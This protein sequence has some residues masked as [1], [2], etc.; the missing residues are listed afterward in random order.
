ME[1]AKSSTAGREFEHRVAEILRKNDISF[2]EQVAVGGV[3]PDFLIETTD[4]RFVIVEAK[5]WPATE[6]SVSRAAREVRFYREAIGV[7]V[8]IVVLKGLDRGRPAEGVVGEGQLI[9]SLT[10]ALQSRPPSSGDRFS[11][12]KFGTRRGSAEIY[13]DGK[14]S[15]APQRTIFAAMPF[16]G[17]YDDT[18]FVAMAHAAH[19]LGAVC[20]RIDREDF[21]GD[22]VEGI[23]KLIRESVAVIADLSES[24]PNVLYETGF[25]HALSL[26][27]VHICSSPLG[28]LPFDVRNWNTIEYTKGQTYA[29][30]DPLVK[31]LAGLLENHCCPR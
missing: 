24:K 25:A 11:F 8:P 26:P 5:S 28:E 1:E 13:V 16:S 18:Y 12:R 23:K 22:I 20:R 31:R 21:E 15:I 17:D 19:S 10:V 4:G 27:T 6:S 9:D 14:L 2:R 29:L 3:E 30:R 7:D